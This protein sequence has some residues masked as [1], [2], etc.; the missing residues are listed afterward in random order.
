MLRRRTLRFSVRLLYFYR[1]HDEALYLD[2]LERLARKN[3]LLR[4]ERVE[5]G[6]E[7]PDLRSI[8][9]AAQALRGV[10]CYI[11]G[12]MN[13]AATAT[14]LLRERGVVPGNIHFEQFDFR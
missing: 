4:I 13:M 14:V 3:P 8:L 7:I 9:P 10:E 5:T 12:P 2:E 6:Q 1:S 11:C